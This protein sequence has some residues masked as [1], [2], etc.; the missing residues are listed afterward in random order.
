MYRTKCEMC[1][2]TVVLAKSPCYTCYYMYRAYCVSRGAVQTDPNA[3]REFKE[4]CR[5]IVK[6]PHNGKP[7]LT[8]DGSH[9]AE[10]SILSRTVFSSARKSAARRRIPFTLTPE[11]VQVALHESRFACHYCGNV[12]DR[13]GL[14]RISSYGAYERS[15]VVVCCALCNYM[16][17]RMHYT[18][19]LE[20]CAY[21]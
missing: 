12:A 4:H 18:V 14:D 15:N 13:V 2:H 16:K 21:Q 3:M 9:L 6:N 20:Y 5:S 10:S 1:N 8:V 17:G 19:F 7:G 11:D